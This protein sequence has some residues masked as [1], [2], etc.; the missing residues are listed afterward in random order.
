MILTLTYNEFLDSMIAP[1]RAFVDW[2]IAVA[3]SLINNYIIITFLGICLFISL[4]Y[5]VFYDIIIAFF[6]SH[7]SSIEDK[8]DK[9]KN[10][11]L[12]QEIKDDYYRDNMSKIFNLKYNN[13]VISQAVMS[14]YLN[15]HRS[16]VEQL[17]FKNYVLN[18]SCQY[19]FNELYH[20]LGYMNKYTDLKL[21]QEVLNDFLE[22]DRA[23]AYSTKFKSY[24]LAKDVQTRYLSDYKDQEINLLI[25][26]RKL[27]K[28]AESGVFDNVNPTWLG[29]DIP[30]TP[31]T[32]KEKEQLDELLNNFQGCFMRFHFGVS[33]R[34]KTIKKFLIPIIIGLLA[35]FG[36][37]NYFNN[38]PLGFIQ[39]NAI[40]FYESTDEA[41]EVN[42]IEVPDDS[43]V[44]SI[45]HSDIFNH[46]YWFDDN[47]SSEGLLSNIYILLF[48]YCTSMSIL[49]CL[50][51]VKGVKGV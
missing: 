45:E 35:Y 15:K 38:L 24:L 37:G 14:E 17:R 12:Y 7:I 13:Y 50:A 39:V 51:Y 33:F 10:Y 22:Q 46:I 31:M 43:E 27:S 47:S 23:L 6:D 18:K 49:K 44:E 25:T 1:V 32:D 29:K 3:D 21:S 19:Y 2:L 36:F 42:D 41:N 8:L 5:L 4:F 20:D 48:L 11:A 28:A 16:D 9:K 34:W 40:E 26:K 30:A